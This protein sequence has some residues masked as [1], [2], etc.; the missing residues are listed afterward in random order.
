MRAYYVCPLTRPVYA[1]THPATCPCYFFFS[2]SQLNAFNTNHSF[3]Q[4]GIPFT[5]TTQILPFIVFGIGLDDAFVIFGEFARTDDTKDPVERIQK[6]MEEV[7]LS[8]FLTTLTTSCAFALGCLA[9]LPNLYWLSLYAFPTIIVDFFVMITFFVAIIVVD[10]RR[11]KQREQQA[12]R[13]PMIYNVV[14]ACFCRKAQTNEEIESMAPEKLSKVDQADHGV[15]QQSTAEL[16]FTLPS[17][18][19]DSNLAIAMPE[20]PGQES[21]D[22]ELEREGTL[23]TDSPDRDERHESVIPRQPIER[24]HSLRVVHHHV[25]GPPGSAID[26]FMKWY[27]AQLLRKPVKIFVLIVFVVM[28]AG[29]A[30]SASKFTQEFNIYE[31]LSEDSYVAGYFSSVDQYAD[32]GFVVPEVYFRNVNQSDPSIQKQM[33]EYIDD[34]VG[35]D[36]ITGQPAFFWLRHFKE[37][38]AIDAA[39][40]DQL[41]YFDFNVQMDIFLFIPV[42][43]MLYGD[44]IIRDPDTGDILAS[45]CVIYMDDLDMESVDNQIQAWRDQLDVTIEQPINSAE[46]AESGEGF[47]FFMWEG[48]M[49]YVFEFYQ[50]M[51]DELISSSIVGWIAV[52]FISFAFLPHWSAALVLSP[53]MAVLYIDLIGRFALLFY[54][55]FGCGLP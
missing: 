24:V 32:R 1:N 33:E 16:S 7:G 28:T 26:L 2:L 4:T 15:Q 52:T 40:D 21:A 20:G 48:T 47:N 6:T 44:H 54:I 12:E 37:M 55:S 39:G 53:I 35:I 30:Y 38:L 11:I 13:T 34:L 50:V 10:E 42:F 25:P 3:E 5:S 31:V 29:L 46:N 41:K 17:R 49:L 51:V 9:S 45:R 18:L 8:V 27:A 19:E 14:D 43:K 22:G 23:K 36:S